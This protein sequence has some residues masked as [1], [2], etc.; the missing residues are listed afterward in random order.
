MSC[1]RGR[2]KEALYLIEVTVEKLK[3]TKEK[4]QE[5]NNCPLVIQIKVIDFP[6]FEISR[7]D[8]NFVKPT[9]LDSSGY[10]VFNMGKCYLFTKQPTDLVSMMKSTPM[11]IEICRAGDKFPIAEAD[12]SLSACLCDMVVPFCKTNI[13][14]FFFYV[15]TFFLV[16]SKVKFKN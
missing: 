8:F 4:A 14:Y 9:E 10:L 6:V 7:Q 2:N 12:M 11:L 13:N 5:Y 15:P 1:F 3:F 16:K